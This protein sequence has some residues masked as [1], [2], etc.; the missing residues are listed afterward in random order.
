MTLIF[1]FSLERTLR[2]SLSVSTPPA[3]TLILSPHHSISHAQ[4]HT[5][6]HTHSL[7]CA[8][9]SLPHSHHLSHTHSLHPLTLSPSLSHTQSLLSLSLS[10]SHIQVIGWLRIVRPGSIIG[11]QQQYMRDM[12]VSTDT[13]TYI[14]TDHRIVFR[15]HN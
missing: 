13:Y 7:S 5:L 14:I 6:S 2:L 11:P 4:T 8:Q 15:A 9:H 10:L 3:H 1:T 12:Q